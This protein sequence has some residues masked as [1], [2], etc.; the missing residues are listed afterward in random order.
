LVR[1]MARLAILWF[2]FKKEWSAIALYFKD[3]RVY[4]IIVHYLQVLTKM[5]IFYISYFYSNDNK[6]PGFNY[7]GVNIKYWER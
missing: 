3:L 6:Y 1:N 7:Y 4:D 2:N 5:I